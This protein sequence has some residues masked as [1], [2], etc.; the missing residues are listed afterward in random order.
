MHHV[1]VRTIMQNSVITI[2]PEALLADA[3]QLLDEFRIRRLPVVDKDGCLVG[4]VTDADIRE[5][6]AASSA[7]NNYEPDAAEEWLT[8]G[9]I[10]SRDVVTVAPDAT[11]G[12]LAAVFMTHKIGGAPVVEPDPVYCNRMRLVGIV[13]E[14]DIFRM[15]ATAWEAEAAAM[16]ASGDWMTG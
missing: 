7:V 11:L 12:E 10:M 15:I 1:H 3:G 8:V 13:T 6:E 5:A 4:I 16:Q 9:D 14:T 2:Q